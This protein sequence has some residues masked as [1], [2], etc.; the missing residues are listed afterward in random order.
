MMILPMDHI[1]LKVFA[2]TNNLLTFVKIAFRLSFN[3]TE[4]HRTQHCTRLHRG[5]IGL[6]KA[7]GKTMTATVF[8]P[9]TDGVIAALLA[10]F[11]MSLGFF[12]WD[13]RWTSSQGSAFALNMYKCTVASVWFA[14]M[15]GIRG[16]FIESYS[17]EVLTV[18]SVGYLALS[19]TLGIIFGDV[20]WLEALR[21]L[22]AKHVIVADSLKPFAA[23]LLGR[24]LLNEMLHPLG[25][26]GLALTVLGV[27]VVAWEG[28]ESNQEDIDDKARFDKTPPLPDDQNDCDI[29]T[30]PTNTKQEVGPDILSTEDNITARE[31]SSFNLEEY[32]RGYACAILNVLA[33]SFGSFLTKQHGTGM[34]TWSINLIRFGFAGIVLVCISINMR[35]YRRYFKSKRDLVNTRDLAIVNSNVHIDEVGDTEHESTS[36]DTTKSCN[37]PT[38]FE[39]P[40]LTTKGWLQITL[41]VAFVTFLCPALE[42]HALMQ[43]ALGLCATLASVGPLYGL[44]MDWLF[45]GKRCTGIGFAGVILA[46]GGVVVLCI[47]GI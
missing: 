9:T 26:V 2:F 32:K 16:F 43:I 38:W 8:T 46:I 1:N 44:F 23:A 11:F 12:I 37:A 39:L 28:S 22:G 24:F 10:P 7:S 17:N 5:F 20:L 41:G 6:I 33:D 25:Y 21:L 34:T 3:C 45:K 4:Q 18:T 47:Y 15:A 31:V 27:G 40:S 36:N 42:K 19:S 35:L 14:M 29:T 13:L 30:N